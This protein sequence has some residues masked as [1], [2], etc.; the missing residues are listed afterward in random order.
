MNVLYISKTSILSGG[1]GG[2]ERADAITKSLAERGHAVTVLSGKTTPNLPRHTTADDRSIVHIK[3]VPDGLF[4]WPTLAF[5]ATRYLFAFLSLPVL[6]SLLY[7]R[8]VEILIENMTPYPT[9]AVFLARF[10]GIPIVAVQ[11]EFFD[12]SSYDLYD[13]LTA[14][15]QLLV[16]NFLRL[17]EYEA[18]IVPSAH[19]K[20][21]FVRYGVAEDRIEVVPNGI[22]TDAYRRPAIEPEHGRLLVIGRLTKRKNHERLLRALR[23]VRDAGHSVRLDIAGEGPMRTRLEGVVEDLDLT[24]AV[25]F[26]GFVSEEHKATLLNRAQLFVFAS[27]QEGFGI[28]L[29][30]AMSVGL[31]VVAAQLPVYREFVHDG[32]NGH[33]I[34]DR[35]PEAFAAEIEGLLEDP[36]SIEAM[37]QRARETAK[38][39]TWES[40]A[41][42]TETVLKRVRSNG[43][44]GRTS[45]RT[46]NQIHD[47]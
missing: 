19:T 14:S 41:E 35:E 24:T 27:E 28:V 46:G 39:Y 42:R 12:A 10:F 3:C 47:R 26:H 45:S 18:L 1:G 8:D 6:A 43:E 32:E 5:Y 15:I 16:Q 33:L 21:Q 30:E 20:G 17:F 7:R 25:R 40:A 37:G 11:H 22:R 44:R 38:Q 36:A 29:L 23:I 31:P 13:P 9:F 2:E 34:E 4:R